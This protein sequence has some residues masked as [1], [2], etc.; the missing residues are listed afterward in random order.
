MPVTVVYGA[1]EDK[2]DMLVGLEFGEAIKIARQTMGVS[3][4][5][6]SVRLNGKEDPLETRI[7]KD[8]D[9]IS[10]YKRSGQKGC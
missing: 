6:D 10:F 5:I 1:D 8:G 7:V 2:L 4:D 3:E 9:T